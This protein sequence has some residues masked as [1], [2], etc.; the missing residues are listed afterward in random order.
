MKIDE[1]KPKLAR[2]WKFTIP[3]DEKFQN[4]THE[5]HIEFIGFSDELIEEDALSFYLEPLPADENAEE[6]AKFEIR[7]DK[8]GNKLKLTLVTAENPYYYRDVAEYL[9]NDF[10]KIGV[11]LEIKTLNLQDFLYTVQHREYD[12]LLY[13]QNLGY[14]LDIYEFFHES[15]VGKDNLSDYQNPKASILIEEIRSSHVQDVRDKKLQELREVFK[16]DI[17]AIFLF[18]PRYLYYYDAHIEN[19]GIRFIA[20]HKDRFS[21]IDN[22]YILKT[23]SFTDDISWIDFPRWFTNNFISFITFS[24]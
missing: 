2:N 7:E 9:Q 8:D 19:L 21:H 16:S 20:F 15:Q 14:N 6:K 10:G 24:L 5:I 4:E 11:E 23:E 1:A 17:P 18:S 3:F 12:I 22:A 13:G